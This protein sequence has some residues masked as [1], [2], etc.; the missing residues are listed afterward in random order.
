MRAILTRIA[1]KLGIRGEPQ[2]AEIPPGYGE[3]ERTIYRLAAPYTSTD[4]GR[5][6]ALIEAVR[7]V[8]RA[9][10]PGAIVECGVWRGGSMMVVAATLL[11]EGTDERELYLF[12]TFE[13]MTEPQER[14]VSIHGLQATQRFAETRKTDGGSDWCNA[15]LEDVQR[16]MEQTNYPTNRV[17]YVKGPV[18]QTLPQQAPES[19]ALLR[20]DTDWYAS[21]RHE[22]EHLYPRLQQGGVLIIDDY[23]WWRGS[24]EAVDEYI[25]TNKLSLYLCPIGGGAVAA[26]KQQ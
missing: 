22:M 18:E 15:S 1:S 6:L 3:H 23:H 19:I 8:N 5:V 13:G 17:H 20:L 2:P 25:R 4:R 12:D 24:K 16:N 9:A 10:V 21:T 11:A 7:H 26:I 14:D